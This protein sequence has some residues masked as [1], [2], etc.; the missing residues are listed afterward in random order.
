[1]FVSFDCV[2]FVCFFVQETVAETL[3]PLAE[4]TEDRGESLAS[5]AGACQ[6][7]L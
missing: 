2:M 7:E 5:A 4:G 6:I 3:R 1:M